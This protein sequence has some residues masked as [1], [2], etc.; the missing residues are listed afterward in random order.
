MTAVRALVLGNKAHGDKG[1][2]V[3]LLT[4]DKGVE[5]IFLSGAAQQRKLQGLLVLGNLLRCERKQTRA[6]ARLYP[7]AV[8]MMVERATTDLDVFHHLSYVLEVARSLSRDVP[9]ETQT[10]NLVVFYLQYL[11]REG[12]DG[13]RLLTWQLALFDSIGMRLSPWPCR[14]TGR[15][16]TGFSL[17]HGGAVCGEACHSAFKVSPTALWSLNQAWLSEYGEVC[18]EDADELHRLFA[19]V[20]REL[21]GFGLKSAI[22]LEASLGRGEA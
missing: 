2:R 5:T 15:R 11:E 6:R 1:R 16:P 10:F 18:G 21:L 19:Q 20:W 12:A 8:E 9:L 13:F 3:H 7:V 4:E 14:L 17:E 22:F